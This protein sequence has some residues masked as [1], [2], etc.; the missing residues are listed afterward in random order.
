MPNLAQLKYEAQRIA[1]GYLSSGVDDIDGPLSVAYKIQ[2][3]VAKAIVVSTLSDQQFFDFLQSQIALLPAK[4]LQQ[5]LNQLVKA[6]EEEVLQ[7]VGEK[8]MPVPAESATVL[9]CPITLDP[10]HDLYEAPDGYFY[11]REAFL[12][13]CRWC[14]ENGMKSAPSPVDARVQINFSGQELASTSKSMGFFTSKSKSLTDKDKIYC[15][16]LCTDNCEQIEIGSN[17]ITLYTDLASE[18]C[19]SFERG[20]N[21]E[22]LRGQHGNE[23]S[24]CRDHFDKTYENPLYMISNLSSLKTHYHPEGREGPHVHFYYDWDA[25]SVADLMHVF[26]YTN[27]VS[28]KE[29]SQGLV[30]KLANGY[31]SFVAK[32]I[33][34]NI[35]HLQD[36]LL[37]PVKAL[38]V[39]VLQKKAFDDQI[40]VGRDCRNVLAVHEDYYANFNVKQLRHIVKNDKILAQFEM[41]LHDLQHPQEVLTLRASEFTCRTH[42]R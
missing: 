14:L 37:D 6:V 11:E 24:I 35:Q 7:T 19:A 42:S 5:K 10:I 12:A 18:M 2:V 1:S 33:L 25:I 32:N 21:I 3:P 41:M 34:A 30:V 40:V 39:K 17:F 23:F 27:A 29:I 36:P 22:L 15:F 26:S 38:C 9:H 31:L 28:A 4:A 20:V 13:W 16:E 8:I